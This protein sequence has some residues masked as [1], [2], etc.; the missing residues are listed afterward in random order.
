MMKQK[1]K[2]Y[3]ETKGFLAS[4]PINNDKEYDFKVVSKSLI[5]YAIVK[6][7]EINLEVYTLD[8]YL[9]FALITSDLFLLKKSLDEVYE[10]YNDNI[11]K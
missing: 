6:N 1:L 7:K 8:K 9:Y 10:Q 5:S 3:L 11:S 2:E 4:E